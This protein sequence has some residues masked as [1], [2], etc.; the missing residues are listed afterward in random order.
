MIDLDMQTGRITTEK[1]KIIAGTTLEMGVPA[2]KNV[3]VYDGYTGALLTQVKT[4]ADGRYKIYVPFAKSYTI[5]GIDQ[6]KRF[7][8]TTQD[9]VVPK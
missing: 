1:I 3:R 6:N 9:N 8:A 2:S 4:G 5:V 7:N